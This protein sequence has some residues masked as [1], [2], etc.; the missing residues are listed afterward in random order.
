MRRALRQT[1]SPARSSEAALS[2]SSADC[3]RRELNCL[4]Q[5]GR[6]GCIQEQTGRASAKTDAFAC[7]MRLV[8]ISGHCGQSGQTEIAVD[9]SGAHEMAESRNSFERLWPIP[10]IR[11]KSATQMPL[12]DIE[13]PFERSAA[14][15]SGAQDCVNRAS[16]KRIRFRARSDPKRDVFLQTLAHLA[17]RARFSDAT[18]QRTHLSRPPNA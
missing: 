16:N 3:G 9:L 7:E 14:V 6:W 18:A 8:S 12:A 10:D 11:H 1:K 13:T 17:R 4:E 15:Q 2:G 5:I